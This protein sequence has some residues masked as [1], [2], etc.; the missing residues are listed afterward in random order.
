MVVYILFNKMISIYL[1]ISCWRWMRR[2]IGPL[3]SINLLIHVVAQPLGHR[4]RA[5]IAYSWVCLSIVQLGWVCVW[6][7]CMDAPSR[8]HVMF[9]CFSPSWRKLCQVDIIV[10]VPQFHKWMDWPR[11]YEI[12]TIVYANVCTSL[13]E[14]T[15]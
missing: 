13:S 7:S 11:P 4:I 9:R 15:N 10:I 8:A 12:N 6:G 1:L 3:D 5:S 14:I 2:L